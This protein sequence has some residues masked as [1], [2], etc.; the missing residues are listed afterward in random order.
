M[1]A[2][3]GRPSHLA[4][5]PGLAGSG[6]PKTLVLVFDTLLN[7]TRFQKR[8]KTSGNILLFKIKLG[9]SSTCSKNI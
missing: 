4:G 3:A 2:W 5:L 1:Q 9:L 7:L 8:N 6:D